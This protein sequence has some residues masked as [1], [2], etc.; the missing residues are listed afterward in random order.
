MLTAK[1][2]TL[3]QRVDISS[4]SPL[5]DLRPNSVSSLISTLDDWNARC[6]S[7]LGELED[8]IEG[9]RQKAIKKR[10]REQR[11]EAALDKLVS[12]KDTSNDKG[13]S[14]G[15]R[16]AQEAI[17]GRGVFGG[18]GGEEMDLDQGRLGGRSKGVKR[19]G[20]GIKG[21]AKRMMG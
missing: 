19:G 14:G 21:A 6:V 10:Q 16:G 3:A 1:L 12:S 4:V 2:D 15:K 7:V 11:D 13:K 17:G 9:V 5:R 20:G 8:Q 18:E